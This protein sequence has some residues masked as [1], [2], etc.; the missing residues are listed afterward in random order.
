MNDKVLFP[1]T[2]GGDNDARSVWR[3]C[4]KHSLPCKLTVI[5]PRSPI[6]GGIYTPLK[7]ILQEYHRWMEL[8]HK[9]QQQ[10]LEDKEF[11]E[12]SKQETLLSPSKDKEQ[13][14]ILD[15][16]AAE[17]GACGTYK[18]KYIGEV[19]TGDDG[20]VT[21]IDKVIHRVVHRCSETTT[22]NVILTLTQIAVETK[23]LDDPQSTSSLFTHK[24][25]DISSCGKI[26]SDE[27]RFCYIAGD[28]FCTLSK[29]F[30]GYVFEAQSSCQA[31]TILNGIYQGF[32]R[33]T[34]FM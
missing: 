31:K 7:S 14:P 25:A 22:L 6:T 23:L 18:V 15:P 34:W 16:M 2:F 28:T 32:K 10:K 11:K 13:A 30:K 12:E 20:G 21:Q 5:K 8:F 29:Q 3:Y 1:A 27:L 19:F 33:T 26:V 24:Y 4:R 9:K 17:E